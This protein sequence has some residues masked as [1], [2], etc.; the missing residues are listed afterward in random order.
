MRLWGALSRAVSLLFVADA[1]AC[2]AIKD[3]HGTLWRV[4]AAKAV[5]IKGRT[6]EGAP[7]IDVWWDREHTHKADEHLIIRQ[8]SSETQADVIQLTLAQ[9]YDLLH[10]LTAAIKT[11]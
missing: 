1:V 8:V 5:T 10:A 11:P 3:T 7:R 4:E 9:A 2:K 6:L